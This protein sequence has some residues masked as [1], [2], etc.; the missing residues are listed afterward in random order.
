MVV[1]VVEHHQGPHVVDVGEGDENHTDDEE[2]T[3]SP[4]EGYE[5]EYSH[6][7]ED[8]EDDQLEDDVRVDESVVVLSDTVDLATGKY[9]K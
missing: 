2:D 5:K 7:E 9:Q 8:N 3:A 6:S 4:R 1:E